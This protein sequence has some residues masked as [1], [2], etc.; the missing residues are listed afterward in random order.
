MNQVKND[1]AAEAARKELEAEI[2]A[3]LLTTRPV[4]QLPSRRKSA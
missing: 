4:S 1:A 3:C 2:K